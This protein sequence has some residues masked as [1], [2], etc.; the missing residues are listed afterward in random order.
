MFPNVPGAVSNLVSNHLINQ[1]EFRN[2]GQTIS[3]YMDMNTT[4]QTCNTVETNC[5]NKETSFIKIFK[6]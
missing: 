4:N 6:Y 5:R 3:L 2:I 1:V